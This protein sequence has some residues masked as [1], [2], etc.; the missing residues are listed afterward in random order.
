MVRSSADSEENATHSV[1]SSSG[2][3]SQY[4]ASK[5]GNATRDA[6]AKL[7]NSNVSKLTFSEEARLRAADALGTEGVAG[8]WSSR[9]VR[10]P[11][12]QSGARKVQ[13]K[14]VKSG[15]LD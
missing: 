10:T 4:N 8:G 3:S 12:S 9:T 6:L 5:L 2:K 7:K 1:E 15:P 11:G 14:T 13:Q